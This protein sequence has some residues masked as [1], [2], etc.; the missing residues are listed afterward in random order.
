MTDY[1]RYS[2]NLGAAIGYAMTYANQDTVSTSPLTPLSYE[3]ALH[4]SNMHLPAP[5]SHACDAECRK[6]PFQMDFLFVFHSEHHSM[7]SDL[8][9]SHSISVELLP[10]ITGRNFYF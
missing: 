3:D 4:N 5:S 8:A 10:A 9:P 6:R 7:Q 2:G 1:S